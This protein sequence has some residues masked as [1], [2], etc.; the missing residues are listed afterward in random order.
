MEFI[1]VNCSE[2]TYIKMPVSWTKQ[3][4]NGHEYVI[5]QKLKVYNTTISS[6]NFYE[7]LYLG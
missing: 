1:Q 2:E 7:N 6:N 5:K 3:Y 4:N